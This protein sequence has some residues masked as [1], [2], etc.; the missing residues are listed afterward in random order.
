M[1]YDVITSQAYV[2]IHALYHSDKKKTLAD[3][4]VCAQKSRIF[5]LILNEMSQIENIKL[6][7][8]NDLMLPLNRSSKT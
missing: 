4:L 7:S 6:I 1:Y 5:N 2:R 3:S 8:T